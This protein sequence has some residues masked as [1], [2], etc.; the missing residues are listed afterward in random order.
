MTMIA[1]PVVMQNE[2]DG[3]GNGAGRSTSVITRT[4]AKTKKPNLYRVLLLNDAPVDVMNRR[5]FLSI[6][7]VSLAA[8]GGAA[9]VLSD[10]K[11][12]VRSDITGDENTGFLLQ[13]LEMEILYLASLAP[14]GHNTQPWYIKYIEPWHW[15]ICNDKTRWLPAVDPAQRETMLSIGA[16][17]QNLEYAACNAG[18]SCKCNQLA[19]T[20]QDENIMEVMLQKTAAAAPYDISRIINRRTLRSG[21]LTDKLKKEDAIYLL[22]NE[23]DFFHFVPNGS[24]EYQWL[25]EQTIEANRVQAGRDAAQKELAEWIRFSGNE[26]RKHRDGLTTAS[27]ELD[28][29]A[30]WILRNF[31]HKEDVLKDSFRKQG[32]DKIKKQVS[33]SAGWLVITGNGNTVATLLETGKRFQRLFLCIR[34]KKIAIHPMTQIL[35]EEATKIQVNKSTGITGDIQFILRVGYVN[36]YP[37]PVSLRRPVGSIVK[38]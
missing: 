3:D 20:S 19:T 12:I 1:R 30:G 6:A 21:Y 33:Q 14:S 31:Y 2:K 25:N 16:F 15:I 38:K 24:K 13:P 9:Y 17:L 10:K 27:M 34:E 8:A 29:M 7:G 23:P 22:Q 36:N 26:A 11:N 32:V 35:E 37:G 5:R 18:Y 4:K 28:G